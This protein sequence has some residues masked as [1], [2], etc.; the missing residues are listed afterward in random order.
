MLTLENV[1]KVEDI[2]NKCQG[3]VIEGGYECDVNNSVSECVMR[4][5]PVE[6]N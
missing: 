5:V 1:L 2:I 6:V 3:I 4:Q